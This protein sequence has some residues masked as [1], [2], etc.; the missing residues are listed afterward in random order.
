[1]STCDLFDSY[2]DGELEGARRIEFER[3]LGTCQRCT[4]S[5]AL[6]NNLAAAVSH[7]EPPMPAGL[8]AQIAARAFRRREAWYTCVVDFVR[9]K[10][11]WSALAVVSLV[12]FLLALFPNRAQHEDLGTEYQSLYQQ[13]LE[14]QAIRTDNDLLG[15]LERNEVKQ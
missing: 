13:S 15:W 7:G 8:A 6:L 2:R 5:Q 12:L 9:P 3:H 4:L 11:A 1:M 14:K 10:L